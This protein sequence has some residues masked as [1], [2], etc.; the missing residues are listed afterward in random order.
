MYRIRIPYSELLIK[1]AF[2]LFFFFT[3]F[4]AGNPFPSTRQETGVENISETNPVNQFIKITVFI[5]TFLASIYKFDEI[6]NFIK[7][8]KFLAIFLLWALLSMFWSDFPFVTFKRWFQIFLIY[9]LIITFLTY[10]DEKEVLKILKLILYPYLFLTLIVVL[11]IP[12][13]KDPAFNTWRGFSATKNSLGQTGVISSVLTMILYLKEENGI[14]KK[15]SMFF[16]LLSIIIIGGTFSSTSYIALVIFL[17]GSTLYYVKTKIFGR[18]GVTNSLFVYSFATGILLLITIML[19]VPDFTDTV[20]GIFGKSETFYDRGKL[21]KVMLLHISLNPVIGC[22]FQAFWTLENPQL[23]LLYQTFVWLP[24]QAH[25]GY[26][27]IINEVG[28]IGLIFFFIPIIKNIIRSIKN[29]IISM[30]CWFLI[31]PII[32]NVTESN[33]FNVGSPTII[34]IFL[35]YNILEKKF[36]NISY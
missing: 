4:P 15:I 35:S 1:T 10:F 23:L 9:F 28:I 2:F 12:E 3:L 34:F 7:R 22:G 36:R 33:F 11:I 17:T 25:N 18:L 32:I 5:L 8:E 19:F 27:D 21:W 24:N 6:I 29:K 30:W 20:Q 16:F 14:K 13:A 26:L 31:L